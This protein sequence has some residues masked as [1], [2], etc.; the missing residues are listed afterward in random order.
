MGRVLV[1][2]EA[3]PRREVEGTDDDAV[4]PRVETVSRVGAGRAGLSFLSFVSFLSFLSFLRY[5]M[6]P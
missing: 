4:A 5:A 1:P 3:L 6:S 2:V